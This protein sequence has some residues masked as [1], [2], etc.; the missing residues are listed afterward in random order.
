[1]HQAARNLRQGRTG[2]IVA[3]VPNI[4]NPFFSQVLAG[5]ETVAA[6]HG[7]NVL[8]ADTSRPQARQEQISA[9]LQNG[10][11]DGL[12]VLDG[13]LAIEFSR[14]NRNEEVRPAIVFACEWDATAKFPSV[15]IDNRIGARKAVEHLFELG[16]RKIG[17]VCGPHGN[18]HTEARR[19]G[20]QS[21]MR[22]LGLPVRPDW[23]LKGDFTLQ[24]GLDA[25]GEW[26]AMPDRPTA[27]F[28]ASDEMAFGF[29]SGIRSGGFKVPDDVSVVGFDDID[30][31]RCFIPALTTI[32]QPRLEIGT[33]AADILMELITSPGGPLNEP[34][35]S[36]PVELIVRESTAPLRAGR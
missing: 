32:R 6:R 33:I 1:V 8:V 28:C 36:L 19:E 17:H 16:H 24:S 12:I 10:R 11:A 23:F 4:G 15:M 2:A 31:S 14:K 26:M 7:Y 29:I 27:M 3:L 21:T 13:R 5:I 18:V 25:A 30:I 35:R 34:Q 9:Y 22:G 20:M